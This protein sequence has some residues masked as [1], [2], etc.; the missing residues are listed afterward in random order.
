MK[1]LLPALL[2]SLAVPFFQAGCEHSSHPSSSEKPKTTEEGSDEIEFSLLNFAFGGVDGSN[3]QPGG[4][5]I[6]GL[7]AAGNRMGFTYIANLRTWGVTDDTDTPA[8]A[9]FF[10]K[11]NDGTWVGGKFDWIGSSR[12]TRPLDN[13]FPGPNGLGYNGW[14]LANV[15]NP[16]QCAFAIVSADGKRRSNVIAGTWNRSTESAAQ[17]TTTTPG[18]IN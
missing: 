10:V 2:L 17:T 15:P 3:A 5:Q 11:R 18:E 7:Q 4:V 16:C 6:A 12:N 1:K 13:L 9:C 14:N 8:L